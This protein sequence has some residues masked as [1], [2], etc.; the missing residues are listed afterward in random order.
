MA[1]IDG[2]PIRPAVWRSGIRAVFDATGRYLDA[3]LAP[4]RRLWAAPQR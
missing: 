1:S 4:R 2:L 3:Y